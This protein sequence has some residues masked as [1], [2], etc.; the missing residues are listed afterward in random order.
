M[1]PPV[2]LTARWL[3]L[4]MLSY[5]ADP[6]LLAPRVPPGTELDR[7]Q[8]KLY[9]SMVGF[10]FHDTRVRG[11]SI[12]GHR[13]FE[14]VN[15]RFY[16][17]REAN[18]ESRRG[19][20]FVKEI[21]PRRA[22]AWVARRFYNENYVRFPMRHRKTVHASGAEAS[23][24]WRVGE[25][26]NEL[27]VKAAGPAERPPEG[28]LALF[29]TEHTWGYARRRDGGTLEYRV[30][31]PPWRVRRAGSSL[32][33]CDAEALYGPGFASIL[34][35]PPASAFLAD[36]SAVAVRRGVRLDTD[37]TAEPSE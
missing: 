31:H 14:E 7:F 34:A 5:E 9:V 12:P 19:V 23:Y 36:G 24:E 2:F 32:L 22:I 17:R 1:D 11:I 37:E 30:D 13:R 27:S 6:A 4:A 18:G 25:R 21:V 15:L 29:I 20:C 16:V 26:W 35:G 10:R 28:S 8:G 3:D 33:R